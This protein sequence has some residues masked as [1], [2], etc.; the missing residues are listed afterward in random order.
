MLL[1]LAARWEEAL[2]K[3]S[4]VYLCSRKCSGA[5]VVPCR[6]RAQSRGTLA[7]RAARARVEEPRG[8]TRWKGRTGGTGSGG[9]VY[10][11]GE[12]RDRAVYF[13]EFFSSSS[14]HLCAALFFTS[15]YACARV[16]DLCSLTHV[17]CHPILR[18]SHQ[19]VQSS[20]P[21]VPAS[22][23]C[24]GAERSSSART[25]SAPSFFP[26]FFFSVFFLDPLG[27]YRLTV[28]AFLSLLFYM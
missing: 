2:L 17:H 18:S 22:Q 28:P 21:C 19:C 4:T 1:W 6:S 26:F 11:A 12:T 23:I 10:I 25:T 15:A 20:T 9:L 7:L 14:L 3:C 16:Q 27:A 8:G 13:C 24:C 5:L